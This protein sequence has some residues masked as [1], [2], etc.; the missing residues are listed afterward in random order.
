MSSL[1]L[2]SPAKLNLFLAVT[3]RRGD[4]FHDLVSLVTTVEFGDDLRVELTPAP[5]FSLECDNPG[6]PTDD[7]NLI[8]RAATAFK[9]AADYGGG[10]HFVL[11]KRIPQGAGLGGGSSNATTTLLALNQLTGHPLRQSKLA[12][13]AAGVGS[14]C[15]LFLHDGPVIMRGRGE[16]MEVLPQAVRQRLSGRRV[17]IIKP[18]FNIATPWAY[19]ALAAEAPRSYL[20]AAEA[21]R[22]L[23]SWLHSPESTIESLL[24]NSFEPV[25]FGKF[26]ALPSLLEQLSGSFGLATGMSGS[27]SACFAFLSEDDDAARCA[28]I[29]RKV[30]DAWGVGAW[31]A[32]TRLR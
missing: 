30:E 18:S 6:L 15:T 22:R 14:D 4:G 12:A 24:Y 29:R 32:E 10:A 9:A 28:V 31:V 2:P 1:S 19:G 27:G 21:E 23:A 3:G 26:M 16:I 7:T 17:F 13:L 25:A 11:R 8:I 20:P 5:V